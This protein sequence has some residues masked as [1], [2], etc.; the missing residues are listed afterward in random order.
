MSRAA[1]AWALSL[2]AIACG[3]A[4]EVDGGVETGTDAGT[5]TAPFDAGSDA[6]PTPDLVVTSCD[7]VV[8]AGAAAAGIPPIEGWPLLFGERRGDDLVFRAPAVARPAFLEV[9][10]TL[11]RVDPRA[12]TFEI[13]GLALDCGPFAH[14]VASGDPRPD[15]ITLWTRW[16]PTDAGDTASI[17]W[18]VSTDPAFTTIV[19]MGSAMASPDADWTVHVEATDLSAGTTYYYRFTAPDGQESVIG[20]TRTAPTSTTH[21][22][23]A[24]AS[25]SSLFSGYFSAY[26]RIAERDDVD[27]V[28][29]LGD[30]IY[31]F[32]DENERIRVPPSGEVEELVDVASHRRRHAEYLADPDLRLARQAHPWF[33]IWDNHD[34]SRDSPDY[35]GGVQA[36]R[37]WTPIPSAIAPA[38]QIYRALRYGDLI[39]LYAVDMYLFQGRDTLPGGGPSALGTA[40]F[41]WL[42]S[43][44][45][46]S[47]A[48]W[49]I[50]GMQ[51]V[52]AEFGALSGFQELPEARAQLIGLF[53]DEGIDDT[54]FLSGDSHF[55]VFQ[56]V[57][58]DPTNDA[59]P[60]DPSTG[61][62]AVGGEFLPTSISRGNFDEQLGAGA[63]RA[64]AGI[65]SGFLTSN[66]HHVDLELT[67]HGYGIVDVTP[68]RIVAEVWYSPIL[69]AAYQ[70]TFGGAYA[71]PR[72]LNRWARTRIDTPS[73]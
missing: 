55:T 1:F 24:V 27:L 15:A 16:T 23:L 9:E 21:V 40:Q 13:P 34:L 42:S 32:V 61:V 53:R 35:G 37:E 18:I 72:G 11:L 6:G 58:N 12:G 48:T 33:Q 7:E 10:G 29:H 68:E 25:C 4:A 67:S 54:M 8:L 63:T 65:R 5:D 38:D 64:I 39:D 28:V 44:V 62:G 31:D 71:Q 49:R 45:R 69:F 56:D 19:T 50:V 70:E 66:P 46:A 51:K 14:G 30:Y 60:Y 73:R 41:D 17:D 36:F 3:P 26:R 59:M 43:E 47:T 2:S 57:V 52:L 22:R 20:R